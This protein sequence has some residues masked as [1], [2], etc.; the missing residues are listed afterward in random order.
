MTY[1]FSAKKPFGDGDNGNGDGADGDG[2]KVSVLLSATVKR[3][4]VS[5]M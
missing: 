4:G 5:G 2:G 1:F 3:F